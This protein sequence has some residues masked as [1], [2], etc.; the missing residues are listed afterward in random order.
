MA[1]KYIGDT[2][3]TASYVPSVRLA[4]A[5][6]VIVSGSQP[7]GHMLLNADGKEG[8][9]FHVTELV[10]HPRFMGYQGYLRYLKEHNY[11]EIGRIAVPLKNS[12]QACTELYRLLM[13]Q[14]PWNPQP[15]WSCT[16]F[17]SRIV[18]A[19]GG[20]LYSI[21]PRKYTAVID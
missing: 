14:W 19:G 15:P 8:W 5:S 4:M 9:Y 11:R 17:V 6:A 16:G 18:S 13:L 3:V 7:C 20:N 1:H 10:G 2:R 21:C 12:K